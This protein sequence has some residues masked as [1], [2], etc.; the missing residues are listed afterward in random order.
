MSL[1][2]AVLAAAWLGLMTSVSPCPLATNIAAVSFLARRLD[3]KQRAIAGVLAYATGRAVAYI[4]VGVLVAWGIA[5]APQA[6]R[7]LQ[8]EPFIG[9]LLI[10]VGLVLL[11]WIPLRLSFGPAKPGATEGLANR[12]LPGAFL[13]GILFAVTFC[14]TSAA[15]FFGSLLPLTVNGPTQLP[16]FVIYGLATAVPVAVVALAVLFGAQ[17]GAKVLGSVQRWR[18]PLQTVNASLIIAI[19]IYLTLAA[20]LRV[21]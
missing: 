2:A 4:A 13:L 19:G 17:A 10:V 18:G 14:P 9:P 1:L 6:S 5:A 16:L 15:L 8:T 7:F 12:G 20:S 3:T 11:G 21:I